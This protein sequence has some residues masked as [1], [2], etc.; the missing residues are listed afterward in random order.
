MRLLI[1]LVTDVVCPL[2]LFHSRDISFMV[3]IIATIIYIMGIGGRHLYK[4]RGYCNIP[5]DSS[6]ADTTHSSYSSEGDGRYGM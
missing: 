5:T 4:N 6:A 3:I 2:M 1:V